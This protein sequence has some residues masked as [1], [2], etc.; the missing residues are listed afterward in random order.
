MQSLLQYR[1][2]GAAAQA[3]IER[4]LEKV[5]VTDRKKFQH[6]NAKTPP[7]GHVTG[8]VER[9]SSDKD[10]SLRSEPDREDIENSPAPVQRSRTIE[11]VQTHQSEGVALGQV[12]TGIHV[13][14]RHAHEGHGGRVF[15]VDWEGPSDPLDPHNWSVGRRIGVTL[16]ISMIALFVGAA[17]GIDATVLPQA[18]EDFGVSQ[19]AESLATGTFFLRN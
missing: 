4:D 19:V 12:L 17:S 5:R 13:R 6:D 7:D 9:A 10:P 3:Q 8:D 2:A 1:R 18:A 15:V 16:Q 14:H 11:T